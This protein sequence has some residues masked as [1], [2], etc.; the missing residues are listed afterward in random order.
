MQILFFRV[1]RGEGIW[2]PLHE[3]QCEGRQ[4]EAERC[5]G[6]RPRKGKGK[7]REEKSREEKKK[8]KSH[9]TR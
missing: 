4:C 9:L 7:G 8:K 1:V 6:C 5:I 2:H 3:V